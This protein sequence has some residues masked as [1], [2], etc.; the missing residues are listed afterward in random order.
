[1]TELGA[2]A[3]TPSGTRVPRKALG[4]ATTPVREA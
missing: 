1:L 2:H 4:G 3:L